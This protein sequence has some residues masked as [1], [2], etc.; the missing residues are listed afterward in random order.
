M[1]CVFEV[2]QFE[3]QYEFDFLENDILKIKCT[4]PIGHAYFEIEQ[5][6]EYI[7]NAFQ[8]TTF[9]IR[10][11]LK[12]I[13]YIYVNYNTTYIKYTPILTK[14]VFIGYEL[15]GQPYLLDFN[16]NPHLLICGDTG[17]G[18]TCLL[19]NV[20]KNLYLNY[21]D[22]YLFQLRKNDLSNFG[23]VICSLEET[24]IKLLDIQKIMFYREKNDFDM[25]ERIFLVF[26]EFSF[27]NVKS[28]DS[29][30]TKELKNKIF[31]L[32]LD[33][34]VIGRSL[35]IFLIIVSQKGTSDIIPT[36]LKNQLT[37]RLV[38]HIEDSASSVSLLENSDA[39][40]L[41]FGIGIIRNKEQNYFLI[42]EK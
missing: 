8:Y 10:D 11:F 26:E 38:L 25:L 22:I 7:E 37:N 23:N 13:F 2:L 21:S 6:K 20:V 14:N 31:D 3:L 27:Y 17:S 15:S 42:S 40:N 28:Y 33:V 4:I 34:A 35:S 24:Y 18:K 1:E 16:L 36:L 41:G 9:F 39:T 29:K 32:L 5:K 19:Y 30:E 12:N